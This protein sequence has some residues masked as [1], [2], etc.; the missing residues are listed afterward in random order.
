ML[1]IFG[2]ILVYNSLLLLKKWEYLSGRDIS[3]IILFPIF[4]FYTC[5]APYHCG[6]SGLHYRGSW[7][8]RIYYST[9]NFKIEWLKSFSGTIVRDEHLLRQ[10]FPW[11][12]K[13]WTLSIK[14]QVKRSEHRLRL[15]V[16]LS[17]I[18]YKSAWCLHICFTASKWNRYFPIQDERMIQSEQN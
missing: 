5:C 4:S 8:Q 3:C 16:I 2:E 14:D 18:E 1:T 9:L 15:S 13:S 11:N 7:D 17:V 12:F 10:R 6:A